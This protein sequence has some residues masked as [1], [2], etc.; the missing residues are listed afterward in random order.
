MLKDDFNRTA[1]YLRIG[2]TDRCNLRCRYCMPEEGIDFSKRKDLMSYEEIIKLSK[3]FRD[4]GIQ[5]VRITG[6]EPFVR[7][8]MMHLITELHSIFPTL[9]ITTNA[10]LLQH[11]LEE[12]KSLKIGGLN[13]SL[14]TLDRNKFHLITRRDTFNRVIDNIYKSVEANIPTKINMVVMKGVNDQEIPDFIRLG[15]K[16]NVEVRFIEAMPFNQLDGN[17]SVFMSHPEILQLIKEKFEEVSKMNDTSISSSLKY[18]VD[19]ET[20]VGIIPAYTRSLCSSCN[21]IRLTPKG[22]LLN[23]LYSEKGLNLL[24]LI[25]SKA[26][27]DSQLKGHI[28]NAVAGKLSSGWEEEEKRDDTIFNS[29]TTIGG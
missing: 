24:E 8:D 10:T 1:T 29:M 25:R 11:Y 2:V 26:L 14:D 20:V 28:K 12:L 23:C 3:I 18:I 6:G 4:L 15:K 19:N 13:I 16:L 9:H 17:K 7:K 27:N 5:K 22:E 21:R